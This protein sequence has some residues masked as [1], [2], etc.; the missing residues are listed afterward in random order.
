MNPAAQGVRFETISHVHHPNELLLARLSSNRE[1]ENELILEQRC[2]A[3]S[4][5]HG[6]MSWEVHRDARRT[7]TCIGERLCEQMSMAAVV[8]CLIAK[9]RVF[10]MATQIVSCAW[11]ECRQIAELN[12][13]VESEPDADSLIIGS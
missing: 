2:Q 6:Y 10:K 3:A 13:R 7:V 5:G 11:A 12:T 4:P 8:N 9:F 1:L